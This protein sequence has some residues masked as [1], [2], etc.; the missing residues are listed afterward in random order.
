MSN[1]NNV[2]NTFRLEKMYYINNKYTFSFVNLLNIFHFYFN[3]SQ[4][5]RI[6][7]KLMIYNNLLIFLYQIFY[8]FIYCVSGLV[9]IISSAIRYTR[10]RTT[11]LVKHLIVP[12]LNVNSGFNLN[13][14]T[15]T[16]S[17]ETAVTINEDEIL[18]TSLSL[19]PVIN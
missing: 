6:T 10:I 4:S 3:F 9:T 12:H 15:S 1:Y 19:R 11:S 16:Y 7:R 17:F 18:S 13:L 14:R 2:A 8:F 5:K